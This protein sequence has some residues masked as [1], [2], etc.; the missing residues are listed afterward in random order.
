MSA[1]RHGFRRVYVSI[2]VRKEWNWFIECTYLLGYFAYNKGSLLFNIRY[3]FQNYIA[4]KCVYRDFRDSE[5]DWFIEH[6]Y[7]LCYFAYNKRS[8]LI[9]VRYTFQNYI[10]LKRVH[11]DF[12]D[13]ITQYCWIKNDQS[14]H[15]LKYLWRTKDRADGSS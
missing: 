14:W 8:L 11:R 13:Y 12:R 15:I 4:L 9:N 1:H 3:T 6:T 5:M 7:L 2:F 10:A